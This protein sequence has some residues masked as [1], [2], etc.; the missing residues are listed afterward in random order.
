MSLTEEPA[1]TATF[2]A[3][4]VNT[5]AQVNLFPGNFSQLTLGSLL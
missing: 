3:D 1:C 2:P 5:W 4:P